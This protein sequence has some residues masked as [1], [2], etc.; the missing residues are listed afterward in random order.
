MTCRDSNPRPS[1]QE[2]VRCNPTLPQHLKSWRTL[3]HIFGAG[4]PTSLM[5]V[6]FW[7][8]FNQ[9]IVSIVVNLSNHGQPPPPAFFTFVAFALSFS[10][11]HRHVNIEAG[12]P[13][14]ADDRVYNN[15]EETF[16]NKNK[17]IPDKCALDVPSRDTTAPSAPALERSK[18]DPFCLA[19]P[20]N[21]Q[22]SL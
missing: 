2:S 14:E 18:P 20:R 9:P 8:K 5:K 4:W 11:W 15:R 6:S 22:N 13:G 7:G 10:S 3:S 17:K 12:R 1:G 21:P 16:E 19:P